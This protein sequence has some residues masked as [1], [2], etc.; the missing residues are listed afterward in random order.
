MRE[1]GEYV[2]KNWVWPVDEA[3]TYVH[4][5][6]WFR[7]CLFFKVISIQQLWQQA[8]SGLV[9][10]VVPI[11]EEVY[12]I[13]DISVV[14]ELGLHEVFKVDLKMYKRNMKWGRGGV[15]TEKNILLLYLLSL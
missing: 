6:Y 5:M 11:V 15:Y 7:F 12:L 3:N 1:V 8:G 9:Q 4:V 14:D 10:W 13:P 2:E